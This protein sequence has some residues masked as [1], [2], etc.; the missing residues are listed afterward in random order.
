MEYVIHS[1][2]QNTTALITPLFCGLSVALPQLRENRDSFTLSITPPWREPLVASG[3]IARAMTRQRVVICITDCTS[4]L[5]ISGWDMSLIGG[6]DC[7]Q[8]AGSFSR[9]LVREVTT[10][11]GF[12]LLLK[13]RDVTEHQRDALRWWCFDWEFRG[14]D[15]SRMFCAVRD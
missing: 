10:I 12:W 3:I 7:N 11:S 1:L 6:Y 9:A 5:V 4:N 8:S 2:K 13:R 14:S 15:D